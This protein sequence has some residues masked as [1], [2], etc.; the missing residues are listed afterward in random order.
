MVARG[1]REHP[2]RIRLPGFRQEGCRPF[3][4]AAAAAPGKSEGCRDRESGAG[5]NGG[6]Y[7]RPC[8]DSSFFST[9]SFP[10]PAIQPRPQNGHEHGKE[11]LGSRAGPEQRSARP[12]D[13]GVPGENGGGTDHLI[14]RSRRHS[15]A[16]HQKRE[17][18]LHRH[19]P[20]E[21]VDDVHYVR[22]R[23][24]ADSG[25]RRRG[26][27]ARI[28][29]RV[30]R[31]SSAGPGADCSQC[32]D[33]RDWGEPEHPHECDRQPLDVRGESLQDGLPFRR[34]IPFATVRGGPPFLLLL[35][36][37]A[38]FLG[39]GEQPPEGR[40]EG[41]Y[42]VPADRISPAVVVAVA[43][44][45]FGRV[46]FVTHKRD[47][48]ED[49]HHLP[50]HLGGTAHSVGPR[51]PQQRPQDRRRLGGEI[52]VPRSEVRRE[53][54]RHGRDAGPRRAREEGRWLHIV[55]GPRIDGGVVAS[56]SPASGGT[57]LPQER[58]Q[59]ES[60]PPSRG[61]SP[62]LRARKRGPFR[63][64]FAD[65]LRCGGEER[66]PECP[67]ELRPAR[68]VREEVSPA[69]AT[70]AAAAGGRA[71]EEPR[72]RREEHRRRRGRGRSGVVRVVPSFSSPLSGG[73]GTRRIQTG[74]DVI[75]HGVHPSG[76]RAVGSGDIAMIRPLL[77]S[78][79]A[80]AAAAAFLGGLPLQGAPEFDQP[81]AHPRVD[82]VE[83]P[84][85]PRRLARVVRQGE[86]FQEETEEGRSGLAQFKEEEPLLLAAVEVADGAAAGE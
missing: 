28:V 17:V 85:V 21:V 12:R 24:V 55:L 56:S 10:L 72:H 74:K 60:R 18:R 37:L 31:R 65:G 84:S 50:V 19:R 27:L 6:A 33:R 26:T 3:R 44:T 71:E 1:I 47:V 69:A 2:L 15:R 75:K 49:L 20:A 82:S 23:V 53:G 45:V 80:A 63:C 76:R 54:P 68:I 67:Q 59:Q 73:G 29:P 39:R 38:R 13:R 46:R 64:P 9:S 35:L 43:V 14:F 41:S 86:Q 40:A 81:R 36:L 62:R 77:L 51:D 42:Q 7:F 11:P 34:R 79:S 70:A 5:A 25:G 66:V 61:G 16:P 32:V 4:A 22:R 57:V 52:G 30:R 8:V 78:P 83:P 48:V 58:R